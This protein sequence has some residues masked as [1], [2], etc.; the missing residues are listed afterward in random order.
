MAS[1][2]TVSGTVVYVA[3]GPAGLRVMDVSK[4]GAPRKLSAYDTPGYAYS[5]RIAGDHAYVAD[6]DAGLR[7]I[8]VSKPAAPKEIGRYVPHKGDVRGIEVVGS[9]AY[10][11]AGY[12]AG[13]QVVDISDTT[14]PRAVG[15]YDTPR[16]ARNV[17]VTGPYAYVGDLEWVRVIDISTPSAPREIASYKTPSY[18]DDIWVADE[19]AY[20]A[21]N[22]SGLMILGSTRKENNLSGTKTFRALRGVS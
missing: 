20:V 7:I 18:A 14:N 17:F 21:A 16:S 4:P 19:T 10:L 9:Y 11:A 22:D 8:D 13:F 1:G 2:I 5:V 6:G 3:D 12:S 15:H